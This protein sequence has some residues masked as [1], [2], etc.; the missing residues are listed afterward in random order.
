MLDKRSTNTVGFI[1]ISKISTP[2]INFSLDMIS[3]VRPTLSSKFSRGQFLSCGGRQL[4]IS[5]GIHRLTLFS[6][7]R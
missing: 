6:S 2:M 5:I 3:V 7:A 4:L 1:L